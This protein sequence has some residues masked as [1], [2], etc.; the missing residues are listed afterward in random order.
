MHDIVGTDITTGQSY[1]SCVS[2]YKTQNDLQYTKLHLCIFKSILLLISFCDTEY[3]NYRKGNL[4]G[5]KFG[6]ACTCIYLYSYHVGRWFVRPRGYHRISNQDWY[7]GI[8]MSILYFIIALF[9]IHVDSNGVRKL[10]EKLN[11]NKAS[12]LEGNNARILKE[13]SGELADILSVIFGQSLQTGQVPKRL[14]KSLST[15]L[16][17]I[18][19]DM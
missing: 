18:S 10:R 1:Q 8:G 3:V 7:K 5:T 17:A 2:K 9:Y 11:P 6:K 15:L 16:S 13:C 4:C 19:W 14:A 12:G